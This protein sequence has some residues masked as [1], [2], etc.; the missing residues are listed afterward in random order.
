MTLV[1]KDKK[2]QI[3]RLN[4]TKEIVA[5][6]GS[7]MNGKEEDLLKTLPLDEKNFNNSALKIF[8]FKCL[9]E[10]MPSEKYDLARSFIRRKFM[11]LKTK[12]ISNFKEGF[13]KRDIIMI[14]VQL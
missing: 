3:T 8:V 12:I 6:F 14:N 5:D 2:N 4:Q 11:E 9:L 1:L 7:I 10:E 13:L